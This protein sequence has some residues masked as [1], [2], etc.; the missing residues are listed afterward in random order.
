MCFLLRQGQ[1]SQGSESEGASLH[2]LRHAARGRIVQPV[3]L[4][5]QCQAAVEATMARQRALYRLRAGIRYVLA[6]PAMQA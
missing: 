5:P 3:R 6:L 1:G 4:V 2:Q